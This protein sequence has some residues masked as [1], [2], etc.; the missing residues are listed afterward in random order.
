MIYYENLIA[1]ENAPI[2]SFPERLEKNLK[3]I[4]KFIDFKWDTER[5]KCLLN[6][7]EGKFHRMKR[8]IDNSSLDLTSSRLNFDNRNATMDIYQKKHIIWI[9]SSI[10]KVQIAMKERG[11]D[12]TYLSRYIS[13]H[14]KIVICH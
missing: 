7:N 9:R 8:C 12:S 2:T 14:V 4:I 5:F 3:E 1:E 13:N 6:D 10:N 11:I